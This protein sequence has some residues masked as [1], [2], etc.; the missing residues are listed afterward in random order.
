MFKKK[1][2]TDIL[3]ILGA[4]LMKKLTIPNNMQLAF[5]ENAYWN[6]D[7]NLNYLK[8]LRQQ[9]SA[10][11]YDE[12]LCVFD[13]FTGQVWLF[14]FSSRFPSHHEVTEEAID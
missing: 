8:W 10:L 2:R 6:K 13:S 12:V 3:H 1:S 9:L 14:L 5:N 4:I 11:G 7:I